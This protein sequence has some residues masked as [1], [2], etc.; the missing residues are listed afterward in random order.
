MILN[1]SSSASIAAAVTAADDG[2]WNAFALDSEGEIV[3]PEILLSDW[4]ELILLFLLLVLG[5]PLNAIALVRLLRSSPFGGGGSMGSARSA[6]VCHS[7]IHCL[8]HSPAE[9]YIYLPSI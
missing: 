7:L 6:K 5:L 2:R 4:I 1:Q 9:I 3:K 8:P